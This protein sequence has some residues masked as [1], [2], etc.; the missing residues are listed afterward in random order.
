MRNGRVR[1]A[2]RARRQALI[3]VTQGAEQHELGTLQTH[4]RDAEAPRQQTVCHLEEAVPLALNLAREDPLFVD[5]TVAVE[6]IFSWR[7]DLVKHNARIVY[8]VQPELGPQVLDEHPLTHG[9]VVFSDPHQDGVH[10]LVHILYIELSEY[11]TEVCVQCPVRDEVFLRE[12]GRA[13]YYELLSFVFVMSGCFHLHSIISVAYF[14][15][16]IFVF[17][18]FLL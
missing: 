1:L 13:V 10:S 9:L 3:A 18:L 4:A 8:A 6:Q 7:A 14:C 5:L 17:T 16:C 11:H 15:I 2:R 12:G